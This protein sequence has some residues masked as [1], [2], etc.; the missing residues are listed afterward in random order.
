MVKHIFNL[1]EAA[2]YTGFS[3]SHLYKLTHFKRVTHFKP[4][5]KN[6]FFKKSDLDAYLLKGEVQVVEQLDVKSEAA[7]YLLTS[8][9]QPNGK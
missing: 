2:E 8:K 7:S 1:S 4:N 5:G 6:I 3:K 9:S